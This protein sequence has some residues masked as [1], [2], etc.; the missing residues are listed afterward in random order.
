MTN[1]PSIPAFLDHYLDT[2]ET[3]SRFKVLDSPVGTI[4]DNDVELM[5]ALVFGLKEGV[6]RPLILLDNGDILPVESRYND[7]KKEIKDYN[8]YQKQKKQE[9]KERKQAKKTKKSP[10]KTPTPSTQKPPEQI[11]EVD[12]PE[13]TTEADIPDFERYTYIIYNNITYKLNFETF[14]EDK[15][16]INS[17][18]NEAI[19]DVVSGKN[20][21]DTTIYD[22]IIK[23]ITVFYEHSST[24]EYDVMTTQVILSYIYHLLGRVFYLVF[25]GSPDSGKSTAINVLSYLC[26]N[27][28]VAGRSTIPSTVRLIDIH[29][30]TPCQDEFEKMSKEER[31]VF[32]AVCNNGYNKKGCYTIA[33]K[34][35]KTKRDSVWAF[36]VFCP[37]IFTCNSMD[38]FD[39]SF[40]N[41]CYIVHSIR[42]SKKLNDIHQLKHKHIQ[43]FQKLRD[44]TFVYCMKHWQTILQD[45]KTVK[46]ELE[47]EDVYGRENDKLSIILGVVKHFR[48]KDYMNEIK[49]YIDAKAPTEIEEK[50]LS[51]TSVVLELL[52]D[53]FEE[54]NSKHIQ[55]E[56]NTI[57]DEVNKAFDN[58][59]FISKHTDKVRTLLDD[60]GLISTKAHITRHKGLRIYKILYN[61]LVKALKKHRFPELEKKLV[62]SRKDEA[63]LDDIEVLVDEN[64]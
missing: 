42:T 37:K 41:R 8:E 38:G 24:Y 61:D 1:K 16:N 49:T 12:K 4:K 54:T 60:F 6:Y 22:K 44:R 5:Y 48:G 10:I 28:R 26:Y 46:D 18:T 59:N 39:V 57:I 31:I 64:V 3:E 7:L 52:V 43:N 47:K 14:W 62:D 32:T 56:N 33:N 13:Y 50:N 53:K 20:V 11:K 23:A 35:T 15:H 51:F 2:P 55:I 17:I 45:I 63:I 25:K 40:I 58:S 30:I 27:G 29:N 19:K 36:K 9:E 34:H 21:Y